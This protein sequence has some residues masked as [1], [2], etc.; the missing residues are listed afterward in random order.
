L[1]ARAVATAL[2]LAGACGDNLPAFEEPRTIELVSMPALPSKQ[3]DVLLQIDD[4]ASTAHFQVSLGDAIETLLQPLQDAAGARF[5]LH[6]GVT[7]SDLG[8]AALLD[9]DHP[10]PSIGQLGNGGCSGRGRDGALLTSGAGITGNYLIE[11]DR[12]NFTGDRQTIIRQMTSVGSGGCGFEQPLAATIHALG[13]HQ[14]DGFRRVGANLLVLIIADEDDCSFHSPRLIDPAATEL[15]PLQ[16]F[17]CTQYG[18]ECDESL[19][20]TGEKHHCRASRDTAY[21]EDVDYFVDQLNKLVVDPSWLTV[22]IIAGPPQEL[23]V[24]LRTPPGGG[25]GILSL[26]HSCGWTGLNGLEV[27]DPPVRLRDFARAF[28]PH[29][30]MSSICANDLRPALDPI[31]SAGAQ[32]FGRACIDITTLRDVSTEPGIQ[33]QCYATEVRDGV[34]IEL[35]QCPADGDCFDLVADDYACPHVEGYTRFVVNHVT[36]PTVNTFIRGRCEVP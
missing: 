32:M 12:N 8:T 25:T 4:S 36:P 18:V 29:G 19:D 22:G 2:L 13:E 35:P 9:L 21:V 34:E 15:G 28:G 33:P 26:A 31:A 3:L 5:D 1:S 11:S 14:G 20:V 30:A 16:S 17:R 6:L 27:A 24:E 23:S 10:G 7:T